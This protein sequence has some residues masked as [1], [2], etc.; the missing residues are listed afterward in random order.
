MEMLNTFQQNPHD[1]LPLGDHDDRA[2][3]EFAKSFKVFVQGRLL[4]GLGP[5]FEKRAAPAFQRREGRTPQ[6]RRDIRAAMLPDAY[7]QHYAAANRIAQEL[8]WDSVLDAIEKELP[9]LSDAAETIS[10]NAEAALEAD[11]DFDVPRYV[12]AIDIHCMPGGY[13]G[14][15]GADRLLPGALYDRGVYLYS[16]GM[17][18]PDNDD[19]GRSVCNYIKRHMPGLQ[20][21]RIL[22]MGCTVGHST[23]PYKETFPEAEVIGIDVAG[24]CVR[25]AHARAHALGKPAA[26]MQRNA[27]D[28]GFENESFD[29]IVSHILLH[30]TSGK[31][32]PR[33]FEECYRLLKPGGV[34]IHADLPPFTKMDEFSQFVLDNETYFN[35]EPFWG[36]MRDVDQIELAEKGRLPPRGCGIR[37][38]AHG[39]PGST[40]KA[41]GAS[42]LQGW[43]ICARWRLGSARRQEGGGMSEFSVPRHAKGRRP[44]FYETPGLDQ[45]M[46]MILTLA[47]EFSVLRDRLDTFERIAADKGHVTREEIDAYRPDEAALTERESQRQSLLRRLY[48]LAAK[49]AEELASD[50]DESRYERTLDE[51]AGG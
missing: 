28:T 14:R 21:R 5:V 4:P 36:A 46:S 51:I 24:P 16:M 29:L 41:R 12:S 11:E 44:H 49:E 17:M 37:H 15:A 23:L 34:M 7:F 27:E 13:T 35:N 26:F 18:G 48:A 25:Y 8:L 38:G 33:I 22:D 40:R 10:A 42:R 9:D 50:D 30:E 20:P 3:Q 31:A 1:V 6:G 47:S 2:R 19:M 43:R 45:A 39:D 32:M